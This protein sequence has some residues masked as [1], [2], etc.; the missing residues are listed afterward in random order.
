MPV[1]PLPQPSLW[2][3]VVAR[4]FCSW[5]LLGVGFTAP[6]ADAPTVVGGAVRTRSVPMGVGVP[7]GCC[8]IPVPPPRA[9][10]AYH[11]V[12]LGEAIGDVMVIVE[13]V[14]VAEPTTS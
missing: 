9:T 7:A 12:A 11:P 13:L 1:T 10:Y 3:P 6:A 2:P 5:P 8:R 4:R 14:V